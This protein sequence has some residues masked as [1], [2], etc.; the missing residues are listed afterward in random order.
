MRPRLAPDRSHG[1]GAFS[2]RS[3]DGEWPTAPAVRTD[4]EHAA[5]LV[6]LEQFNAQL[7]PRITWPAAFPVA[8]A[9]LDQLVRN[10]RLRQVWADPIYRALEQA[11]RARGAQRSTALSRLADQLGRDAQ[12]ASDPERVRALAAVVRQLAAQR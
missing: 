6:R 10:D 12:G 1:E 8:R 5:K 11:E 3:G 7:Q 4:A 9:Y 2:R